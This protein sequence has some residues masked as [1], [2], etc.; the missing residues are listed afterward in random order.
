MEGNRLPTKVSSIQLALLSPFLRESIKSV[1]GDLDSKLIIIPD[2]CEKELKVVEQL[3]EDG[4]SW[5]RLSIKD[6]TAGL[7]TNSIFFLFVKK[8]YGG[9]SND[10]HF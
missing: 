2:T 7:A 9:R 4:V 5:E 6:L 3:L 10:A 1:P 8:M